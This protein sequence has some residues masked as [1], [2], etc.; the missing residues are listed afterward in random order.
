[1]AGQ[2]IKEV[3][4]IERLNDFAGGVESQRTHLNKVVTAVNKITDIAKNCTDPKAL[5]EYQTAKIVVNGRKTLAQ[6][7]IL[8]LE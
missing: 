5:P 4:E 2:F 7:I 8:P 3:G 1:M 6:M